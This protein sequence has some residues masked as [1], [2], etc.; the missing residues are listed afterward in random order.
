MNE[1]L[2]KSALELAD[3]LASGEVTSVELTTACLDRIDA[4][5]PTVHAFLFVDREGAL[6][7]AAARPPCGP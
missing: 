7:T 2:T 4:L 5:N 6:A 1:L 3:L